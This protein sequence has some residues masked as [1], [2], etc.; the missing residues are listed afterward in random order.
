MTLGNGSPP[1]DYELERCGNGSG[2]KQN[3]VAPQWDLLQNHAK[4][5]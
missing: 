5:E 1:L 2:A 4:Q 3:P